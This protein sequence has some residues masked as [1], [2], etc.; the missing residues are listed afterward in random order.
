MTNICS[1]KIHAQ[2][3]YLI[4]QIGYRYCLI[5]TKYY[6]TH[7][8]LAKKDFVRWDR[9]KIEINQ[10]ETKEH[11]N[12]CNENQGISRDYFLEEEVCAEML[13]GDESREITGITHYV[14]HKNLSKPFNFIFI[15]FNTNIFTLLVSSIFCFYILNFS[16]FAL[17]FIKLLHKISYW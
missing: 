14:Q 1:H 11:A 17:G 6:F 13:S 4:K 2:I 9:V 7:L 10:R 3:Y 15:V 8:C 16:K 5:P 12:S